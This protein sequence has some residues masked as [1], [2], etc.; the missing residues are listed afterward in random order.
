MIDCISMYQPWA[1]WVALGWKTIETRRHNK[2]AC[3]ARRGKRIVIQAA[4]RWD[5]HWQAKS[6]EFLNDEQFNETWSAEKD[7]KWPRGALIC[8]VDVVGHMENMISNEINNQE[9][10]CDI[11]GLCGLFL[12]DVYRFN[13]I[14]WKG[15][16]GIM[17]VPE[18]VIAHA[19]KH[20]HMLHLLN[21]Q[22][23]DERMRPHR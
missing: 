2:L 17:K 12:K 13:P 20:A 19:S 18:G 6:F 10:L 5:P 23:L 22:T 16:Q 4:D 21:W 14:P 11:G 9:A 8:T 7:N 15:H 1:Q 3:L